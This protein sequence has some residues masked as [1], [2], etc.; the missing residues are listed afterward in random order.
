MGLK[1]VHCAVTL[2]TM[3]VTSSDK[4]LSIGGVDLSYDYV[5]RSSLPALTDQRGKI[6]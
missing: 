6:G 2:K 5:G 1:Q 3:T 4:R